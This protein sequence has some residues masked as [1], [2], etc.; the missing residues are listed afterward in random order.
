MRAS[1]SADATE[2]PDPYRYVNDTVAQRWR[3]GE[4]LLEHYGSDP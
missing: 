1:R 3:D 2:P 4:Y